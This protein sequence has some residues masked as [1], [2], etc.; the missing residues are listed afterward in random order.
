MSLGCQQ[1]LPCLC[2]QLHVLKKAFGP[3]HGDERAVAVGPE[4]RG[5][6]VISDFADDVVVSGHDVSEDRIGRVQIGKLGRV[7]GPQTLVW[8]TLAS[9]SAVASADVIQNRQTIVTLRHKHAVLVF[10]DKDP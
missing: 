9:S 6:R 3:V 4:D 10:E 5:E 8:L 2:T 7:A 1:R